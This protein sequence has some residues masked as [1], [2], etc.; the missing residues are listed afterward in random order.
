MDE[1]KLRAIE[2]EQSDH[3]AVIAH[4]PERLMD[5]LMQWGRN[6][7][8]DSGEIEPRDHHMA[9]IQE[10][11]RAMVVAWRRAPFNP[12]QSACDKL[13]ECDYKK[14]LAEEQHAEHAEQVATAVLRDCQVELAKEPESAPLPQPLL[15]MSAA[16]AVLTISIAPTLHDAIFHTL[17][18]MLAWFF[19]ILSAASVGF[20]ITWALMGDAWDPDRS[21]KRTAGG[22]IAGIVMAV[23]LGLLR[24]AFASEFGDYIFA[25]GLT[26]AEIAVVAYLEWLSRDIA[27][28][29]ALKGQ[30]LA[31]RT[32]LA[33]KCRTARLNQ[34]HCGSRLRD[35]RESRRDRQ[36]EMAERQSR[37]FDLPPIQ[38][39]AI[40]A[41][42][43]GYFHGLADLRG[44]SLG[45]GGLRK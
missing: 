42:I 31:R 41:A 27:R 23:G 36:K 29:A 19:S 2:G 3:G 25:L 6:F 16:A 15:T 1:H 5:S 33:E 8:C 32:V 44:R 28:A 10:Y 34:E 43:T 22:L 14:L 24:V 26:V 9:R 7:A 18:D 11:A 21:T 37:D 38:D 17:D 12:E 35:I 13:W 30:T 45:I 20:F 39:A 4:A 40:Q